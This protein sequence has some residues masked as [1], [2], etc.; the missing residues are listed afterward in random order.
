MFPPLSYCALSIATEAMRS[1]PD[2]ETSI[3]PDGPL[4]PVDSFARLSKF[5]VHLG[6]DMTCHSGFAVLLIQSRGLLAH[7]LLERGDFPEL[8]CGGMFVRISRP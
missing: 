1:V 2:N 6:H 7:L 3:F 8:R 5:V 4:P